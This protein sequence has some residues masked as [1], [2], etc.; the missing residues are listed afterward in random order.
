[1]TPTATA[2]IDDFIES[3]IMEDRMLR[4][5][6]GYFAEKVLNMEVVGHHIEWSAMVAKLKRIGLNAPRDHGKSFFF[7]FAYAIWRAYYNWIPPD[8]GD[9]FESIPR[10]S[11]GYIFSNTQDQAVKHLQI[12]KNEIESNPKLA[13]LIPPTK[14]T[15][16][17]QEIKLANGAI[18][19]ARGWGV[20]VRGAHPVWIIVDDPLSE[21]SMYSEVTREKEKNY[22]FSAVTPMIV[23]GGQII[24]VGTPFHMNDL[25]QELK[26]N[27][28]YV[29]KTYPALDNNLQNPLWPTRYPLELLLR[30]RSEVGSTRFTREYLCVPISDENTLFPERIIVPCYDHQFEMP[31]S[32]DAEDRKELQVFTGVDLA[33]SATVGADYTVITTLGVDRHKNRWILDIR[34]KRGLTM[35]EQLREIQNVYMNFRPQKI[36]IEDNGF[37]RVFKDELITR[38]DLPVEG[39]TTTAYNKNALDK[40]VPSLQIMFENRKFVIPRKT[41]RDRQVTDVM[42]HE[43]KCMTWVEGKLQGVGA[44]DDCVMSLWIANECCASSSFSFVFA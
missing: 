35:S 40:G 37:Q 36:F 44:H 33:L 30:R 16:S 18:I 31:K 27:K 43:L 15:W 24:A 21:E 10:I 5:D 38:T 22:F 8:L 14:D 1:M 4:S 23:P 19:R 12:I 11:L 39:F 29:F 3:P 2:K 7:C 34:R 26:E 6:L 20:G 13:H 42:I 28:E 9:E 17:K 25:Y 32:L 41:E